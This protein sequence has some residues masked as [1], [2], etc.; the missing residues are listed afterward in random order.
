MQSGVLRSSRTK[1][2][3]P[4]G[5]R[6]SSHRGNSPVSV[7]KL[8]VCPHTKQQ[9]QNGT[10]R[11]YSSLKNTSVGYVTFGNVAFTAVRHVEGTPGLAGRDRVFAGTTLH[12]GWFTVD[13][14]CSAKESRPSSQR[15]MVKQAA[16]NDGIE[17]RM[18]FI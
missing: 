10:M 14:V 6:C 3:I 9:R 15:D 8:V 12:L 13:R 17:K 18:T 1:R 16:T 7:S 5:S 4:G 11:R 2:I